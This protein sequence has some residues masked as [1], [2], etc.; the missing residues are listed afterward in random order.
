MNNK[1]ILEGIGELLDADQK[2]WAREKLKSDT[3]FLLNM[4]LAHDEK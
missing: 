4:R 3:V 1:K 2:K